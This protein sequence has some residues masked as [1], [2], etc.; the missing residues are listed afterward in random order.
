MGEPL[1]R[2]GRLLAPV[3]HVNR[4]VLLRIVFVALAVLVVWLILRQLEIDACL[5]AGGSFNYAFK[6]CEAAGDISYIPVLKR[7]HWYVAVIFASSVSAVAIFLTYK[8]AVWL[9]P[10]SWKGRRGL[11]NGAI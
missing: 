2:S 11:D 6:K 3:N 5:D 8:L 9:I 10:T 4:L 7:E 1:E